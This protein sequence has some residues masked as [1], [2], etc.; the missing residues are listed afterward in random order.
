M[1]CLVCARLSRDPVCTACRSHLSAAGERRLPSGLLV[2]SAWRHT[3]PARVLVHRLKYQAV[4]AA[5]GPLATA[6]AGCLG[7]EP[8]WLV[9]ARRV[10][11]R[12]WRYGID[13]GLEL[14]RAL[15]ALTGWPVADLLRPPP[16]A[17]AHAGASRR[18]RTP[19]RFSVR[20]DPRDP[21]VVIDD[22]LTTG[23][24]LAGARQAL[25]CL[26]RYG[27]TATAAGRV[28]L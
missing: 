20:F 18:A 15:G 7:R 4:R 5:A 9:P 19:P 6:M 26:V 13:P 14:A 2:R 24:T 12:V 3:G 16:W 22:V 10:G 23:A 27:V 8:A 25:G 28:V 11:F 21:V 1:I 17:P